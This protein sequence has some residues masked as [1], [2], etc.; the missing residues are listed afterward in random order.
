MTTAQSNRER[1]GDAVKTVFTQ[2]ST[3]FESSDKF[4]EYVLRHTNNMKDV[5]KWRDLQEDALDILGITRDK[6]ALRGL[7]VIDGGVII[8]AIKALADDAKNDELAASVNY[9]ASFLKNCKEGKFIAA[10]TKVKTVSED[11]AA[12]LIAHGI[13]A[14]TLTNWSAD[15]VSFE[16]IKPKGRAKKTTIVTYTKNLAAAVKKMMKDMNGVINDSIKQFAAAAPDFVNAFKNGKKVI[17][18]GSP[19][20][21][22]LGHVTDKKTEQKLKNIVVEIVELE[23]MT[24]TKAKGYFEFLHVPDGNYTLRFRGPNYIPTE[25]PVRVKEG[26]FSR[27]DMAIEHQPVTVGETA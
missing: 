7:M 4:K 9:S 12:A 3:V 10:C 20:T 2:N 14:Q 23:R 19:G 5:W 15:I 8:G 18:Y 26:A 24:S 22:V 13:S 21:G 6:K 16:N 17:D 27:V 25:I 1:A 11:N